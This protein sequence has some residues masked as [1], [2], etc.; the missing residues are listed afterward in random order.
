M[1][2]FIRNLIMGSVVVAGIV[3]L[4]TSI[5]KDFDLIARSPSFKVGECGLFIEEREFEDDYVTIIRIEQVGRQFYKFTYIKETL[6]P[7]LTG[8]TNTNKITTIDTVYDK[9]ECPK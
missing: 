5:A 8:Q 7:S 2:L 4:A 6:F 9:T 3:L 1:S